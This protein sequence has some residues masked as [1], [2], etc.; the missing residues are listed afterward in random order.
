[1]LQEVFKEDEFPSCIVITFQVMAVA[2]VS[3]G[4]PDAISPVPECGQDKFG[5]DATGTW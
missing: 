3:P 2:G 4:D 5:S 1:M